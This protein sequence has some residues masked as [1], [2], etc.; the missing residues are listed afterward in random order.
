MAPKIDISPADVRSMGNTAQEV[1]DTPLTKASKE[2]SDAYD[3]QGQAKLGGFKSK[4]SLDT[5]TLMWD[6][7]TSCD[8]TNIKSVG[9]KLHASANAIVHGDNHSVDQFKP[10][11]VVYLPHHGYQEMQ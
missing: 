2:M 8:V 6:A 4:D 10:V 9:D 1:A 3:D 7:N 11:P 5:M